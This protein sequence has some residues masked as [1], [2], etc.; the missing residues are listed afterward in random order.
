MRSKPE[1]NS[2]NLASRK[3]MAPQGQE[4]A[5]RIRTPLYACHGPSQDTSLV[6]AEEPG[7][8][9]S[10][11]SGEWWQGWRGTPGDVDAQ[12][13]CTWEHGPM[14]GTDH[15][16]ARDPS[17]CGGRWWGS[18]PAQSCSLRRVKPLEAW[19]KG[20]P[21]PTAC[22]ALSNAEDENNTCTHVPS[23]GERRPWQRGREQPF[24]PGSSVW[25]WQGIVATHLRRAV[26]T[27]ISPPA[28]THP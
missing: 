13:C 6:A 23:E 26:G 2:R 18:H 5:R 19:L 8:G 17:D 24:G 20:S 7:L 11:L 25:G 28:P 22:G 4:R 12:L 10:R 9:V 16:T 21:C 14:Q 3:A 15:S 27:P 1:I